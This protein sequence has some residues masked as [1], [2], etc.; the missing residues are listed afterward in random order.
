MKS[1]D[2]DSVDWWDLPG[3]SSF[4]KAAV[5]RIA[6]EEGG[7]V[8][9]S[10]P[11]RR[12]TGL[13]DALAATLEAGPGLRAVTLDPKTLT[14]SHSPAHA[15]AAAVG[16]QPGTIRSTS[17]FV[18]S[19]ALANMV[20]LVEEIAPEEWG[21]WSLFLRSFRTERLRSRRITAPSLAIVVPHSLP[22]VETAAALGGNHVRWQDVVSRADMLLFVES[23]LGRSGGLAHR[24]AVATVAEAACWDPAI[25]RH[26][27]S[28]RIEDQ[29]DPRGLLGK[30]SLSLGM[31]SWSNGL[32]DLMDGAPHVH[33]LALLKSEELLSRRI[34][35]AHVGTIFPVIEQVR[36]TFVHRYHAKLEAVLPVTKDFFGTKR[37]YKTPLELE[38]N[39]VH[40]YLK[41][42]I[43][44]WEAALLR[45]FKTLRTSMAHMEPAE[46]AL[47]VRASTSWDVMLR[48]A[49]AVANVVGWDWPRCG[50]RLVLLVGPSGAGKT[51]YAASNY[52]G[53]IVLSS[54][55]IRNELYGTQ[56]MAGSQEAVFVA[57]RERARRLLAAGQ[58]VVIDATNLR[59]SD[60]IVNAALVPP[61]IAVEYVLIDRPMPDKQRDGGWRLANPGLLE[62]HARL[63]TA[64]LTDILAGDD[65]PNVKVLDV[66]KIATVSA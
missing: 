6:A 13:I 33:T 55:V 64:E 7:I 47:V 15:L 10:L 24:T 5:D 2:W 32:V 37:V 54:D 41:Q 34:W 30:L 3:P 52:A 17:D 14:P 31:P 45:D 16:A 4:L 49:D 42:D 27:A 65:L 66:R 38:I 46:A 40:H 11:S 1:I 36:Q 59:R 57:L 29:I 51:T 53:E 39:D 28:Q 56:G 18:D 12:P 22:Q 50:Q 21:T 20:F 62:A 23:V 9:L 8:G 35:R 25:V 44:V 19:A 43:P 26:L 63:L 58:S 48:D 60:R 61:D